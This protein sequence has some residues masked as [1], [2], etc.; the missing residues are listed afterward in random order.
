MQIRWNFK[1]YA[2]QTQEATLEEWLVTL[3]K[4]RNYALRERINGFDT[5]NQEIDE[6]IAYSYSAYCEIE[7]KIEYGSCCP[8]TCPILK[9]GVIP[10]NLELATKQSKLKDKQ[11]KE[12]V[13]TVVKWDSASGI[14]MK[15]TTQLRKSL[16]SF[17]T[18]DSDVLQSNIAN[19][20]TA[21]SNFWKHHRGFPQF[22]RRLDSF[23]Y[24]PGRVILRHIRKKYATAYLPG[25]GDVKFHNSRDLSL[26]QNL[27]TCTIKR[28]GG[29]WY[30]SMLVEIPGVL[31]E[32]KPL[33]ESKSVVGIDVGINKLVALSDGSFVENKRPTTNPKTA[34]RLAIRQRAISRKQKGSQNRIKAIKRLAKQKHKLAVGREEYGWQAASKIVKTAEVVAREDLRIPNMVKRAKTK[35]DGKGGYKRNGASQKTGLNRVIL[36]AGWGDIFH[37]IAWLAVKSGKHVVPVPAKH[38]SQ[39]C[40]KCGHVDKKNR[41]GEKFICLVCH[42]TEHADTKASRT[43]AQRVGLVFPN[44]K[45]EVCRAESSVRRAS[46]LPTDCG[47]V[48]PSRYQSLVVETGN[49]AYGIGNYQTVGYLRDTAKTLKES[50]RL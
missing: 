5:N 48:T 19:L 16:E 41:E 34:R 21:F 43:I 7:S 42:Y 26:I 33:S 17:S 14:Q 35:H 25:I 24:K 1:I 45:S 22:I 23:E 39:E 20:D 12:V 11:T 30:I 15:V 6:S 29:N 32:L 2:N 40:P 10:Q 9:H 50:P 37:K 27:R 47:K 49:Q 31:P 13:E 3:R 4:H 8:L 36:D 18:I 38:T 46:P 44:K 28:E